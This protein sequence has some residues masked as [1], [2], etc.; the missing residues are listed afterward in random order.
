MSRSKVLALL[1]VVGLLAVSI[2]LTI[3]LA[4]SHGDTVTIRD[5]DDTNYGDMLS[6]KAMV[7]IMNPPALPANMVYE[8]WLVSDDGS[9]KQTA[10]VMTVGEDGNITHTFMTMSTTTANG[11]T[12]TGPSGENLFA[13][14]DKFVVTV[15]PVPDD[16]PEPSGV[17]AYSDNI[18]AGGLSH[19][20]HLLYSWGGNPPYM[21]G[22][23]E[24]TPKGIA[25]GL[26]EQTAIAL[27]QARL[28]MS[29]ATLADAHSYAEQVINVIEGMNGANYG[30]LDG[31][32]EIENPGDG[33]GVLSYA[34]DAA[35]HSGLSQAG[36][37]EDMRI[38]MYG[39]A[40]AASANNVMDWA[41][42]ARDV[43]M[44]A[45]GTNDLLIAATLYMPTVE[46]L[47]DK[48]LNGGDG[49]GGAMQA[50]S[51]AQDMGT[52]EPMAVAPMPPDVEPPDTG[53]PN[54]PMMAMVVL[55][56][57]AL[58]TVAGIYIYRRSRQSA[59]EE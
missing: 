55:V 42:N 48:S 4:D 57:G 23:H 8:G 49:E 41:T 31:D 2:P 34:N 22:F 46:S 58:L 52:Y 45:L 20:R 36:A 33:F 5:S 19:I 12:V 28:S 9:R 51:A 30:D 47:L 29:A 24:G 40:V 3:A 25:V 15:E 17:I 1:L 27:A 44:R 14:F 32:G 35:V 43:T 54:V 6:D 18:P 39:D 59:Y 11:E 50:Y 37:A 26:R 53:D 7:M 38:A 16:D 13:S 21:S 56:V 10:G